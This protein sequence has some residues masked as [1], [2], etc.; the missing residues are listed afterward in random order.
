M[1]KK[2][3]NK[4]QVSGQYQVLAENR[5]A[6]HNYEIEDVYEAG[7][8]LRGT[9]VKS[10]REGKSN[11]ADSYASA[12]NGDLVLINSYIAEYSAG[13]RNN[14][15]PRRPRK[16]LLHRREIN[17]LA[18]AVQRGGMTLVPLK[19]YF[20]ERGKVKVEIGI[21]RG[22]KLH[23]KRQS[24]KDKSWQRDKARLLREKG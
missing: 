6:R 13:N 12:E 21:A 24:E 15:Q 8:V 14:H 4:P 16:L 9:E 2:G 20:N 22:K 18:G 11:I 23:D 7:I 10:L 3:K 19:L 17:K 1:A 5:K